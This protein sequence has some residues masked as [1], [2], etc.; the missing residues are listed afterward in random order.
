MSSE[1]AQK[2]KDTVV[3]AEEPMEDI[4]EQEGTII[5]DLDF[6]LF[7]LS[8]VDPKRIS[9]NAKRFT[10]DNIIKRATQNIQLLVDQI[11]DLPREDT[12]EG[13]VA[14][15][16]TVTF[17]LP[18]EKPVPVDRPQTKWEQFAKEKGIKKRKRDRRVWDDKREE[19]RARWGKDR[20]TDNTVE[21]DPIVEATAGVDDFAGAVDPFT[22]SRSERRGRVRENKKRQQSNQKRARYQKGGKKVR[23]K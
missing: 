8:A 23:T 20:R 15:I 9:K 12:D 18:R 22:R 3:L 19:Y 7:Y 2:I 6:E 5:D 17:R 1:E 13:P 16:P 4:E 11:F 14:V 21:F 10:E